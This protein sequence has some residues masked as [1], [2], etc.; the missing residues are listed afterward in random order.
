MFRNSHGL[1][2]TDEMVGVFDITGMKGGKGTYKVIDVLGEMIGG[3]IAIGDD[4]SAGR[5][6]KG[7]GPGVRW[8]VNL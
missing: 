7:D 3:A 4:W 6:L 5:K 1:N 8:L 2:D